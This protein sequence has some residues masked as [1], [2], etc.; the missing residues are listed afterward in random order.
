MLMKVQ[1]VG[2]LKT[3]EK[4]LTLLV[5]ARLEDKGETLMAIRVQDLLRKKSKKLRKGISST[6]MIRIWRE[7]RCT[8]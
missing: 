7:K 3:V 8:S 1:E 2:D 4:R 6:R 5:G